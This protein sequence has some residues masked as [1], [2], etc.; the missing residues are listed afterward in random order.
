M[1]LLRHSELISSAPKWQCSQPTQPWLGRGFLREDRMTVYYYDL[2]TGTA[3]T[4]LTSHTADSGATWP[5]DADHY[6]GTGIVTLD[7][8]GGVYQSNTGSSINLSSAAMPSTQ[9]FEVLFSYIRKTSIAANAGLI[10]LSSPWPT[11]ADCYELFYAEG[12]GWLLYHTSISGSTNTLLAGP[13]AGPA[14]GVTWYMKVDV[15]T[16][17]GNTTF[18]VYYSIA[19]T[20]PFTQLFSYTAATSTDL[21]AVGTWFYNPSTASTA[22]TGQHIGALTVQDIPALSSATLSGP[23]QQL[24]SNPAEFT[25][26]LNEP[27]GTSGVVVTPSSSNGSDTFQAT[28]G[29]ANVTSI[30]LAA[31]QPSGTFWLTPG[32]TTGN[33]TVTITSSG[34]TTPGSPFTYDAMPLATS[35]TI[36]GAT[37][38]HQL[39]Q[40]TWTIALV[41]GDFAGTITA[42]P[43]GGAGQCQIFTPC[44]TTF[45]GTNTLSTTFSF[46]P[47]D[48]D[49]VTYTFTNS[50]SMT[51]PA[52]K[53]YTSTGEYL[54]DTFTGTQGTAIQSHT[55]GTLPDGIAGSTYTSPSAGAISLDG[56]GGAYLSTAGTA[57]SLSYATMPSSIPCE[58]VFEYRHLSTI[59]GADSGV[60]IMSDGDGNNLGYRFLSTIN[61][62]GWFQNDAY[63]TGAGSNGGPVI[64]ASWLIKL[65][66]QLQ[67][68]NNGWT[69]LYTQ[70]STD[71]GTTWALMSTGAPNPC[72]I[73]TSS[74]PAAI[75]AGLYFSGNAATSTTG[76]HIANLILQDPAPAPPTCSISTAYVTTSGQSVAF[77]FQTISG[78]TPATPT[79][80]N[81]APSFFRNGTSIGL[82]T[83]AWVTGYHSCAIVQLQPDV[84]INPGDTVTV[85]TPASWMS[86][87]TTNAANSVVCL[88]I[89]N[90]TG[91]SCFG[92][93][94][95]CKTFKP[96]FN[97]SDLG[98]TDGT[99]YNVPKNWRFRLTPSEAGSQN[100]VDGYPTVMLHPTE[101]LSFCSMNSA[102]GIDSTSYPGVPGYW[103]IG[104]DDNYQAYSGA[105]ATTI[106]IVAMSSDSV[107]TQDTTCTSVANTFT[108]GNVITTFAMFKVSQ[109]SGAATA[110]IPIGLQLYN[111]NSTPYISNLWIVAPGDFTYNQGTPLTFDRS[112][113]FAL[114]GQFLAHLANG[115]GSMRWMDATLGFASWTNMSEPWEQH[116]MTGQDGT[117]PAFSWNNSFYSQNQ[118]N[119][120]AARSINLSVS[121][122]V[123]TE[124]TGSPYNVTLNTSINATTT[125]L[126]I[127]AGGDAYAI[128][129][130]GLLLL[131][132][133]EKMRIRSVTG[134]SNPYTVTVERGSSGT[135]AVTHSAGTISCL[136]RVSITSLSQLG[137]QLVE[138]V[139]QSNHNLKTGLFS[140]FGYGSYPTMYFTDGSSNSLAGNSYCVMVTGPTSFVVDQR[141]G[142]GTLGPSTAYPDA[143]TSYTLDPASEYDISQLPPS[144]FP[145]EF[146]AMTTGS[147]TGCNLHV[148]IPGNASDSYVYDVATKICDNFPSGRIVYVEL[149]DEFWNG[150]QSEMYFTQ[151]ISRLCGYSDSNE[152]YVVRTGQI[153]TIFRAVFGSRANE[154]K[155]LL[156]IAWVSSSYGAELLNLAI[157]NGITIDTYAVAPYIDPDN[158]TPSITAWNNSATIQQM[159][160][161]WVHELYYN[162]NGVTANMSSH[163]TTI[164]NYNA[165]TGGTCFIY[166]YEGGFQT[167]V[168]SSANNLTTLSHDLPYDPNWR[169]IEKDFFALLQTSWFHNLNIYSYGIYYFGVNNWGVYHCPSQPYGKGDGSDGK[170]NNRLCL[171]TPGFTYTKAAT[172]NQDQQNVSVRGQAFLEWMQPAQ[173][174]KGML[175][176]PYRFVNR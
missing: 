32:G 156:N 33:R 92:T 2:F 137:N 81:F 65:T 25:V 19:S 106:S 23:T 170:A 159:V 60:L 118:I 99:R 101:Q 77:F 73:L 5:N 24:F 71:G 146:I 145:P 138:M 72:V 11:I 169:I 29:G 129:I 18:T 104:F 155:A 48:A 141:S 102:N 67:V 34:L 139:T 173:A 105:A 28:Q 122:Y 174:K 107:V 175:F 89:G 57:I 47:L 84:Q 82:G 54:A 16:S 31:G 46:T 128:P 7:G 64:G 62:L 43:G 55:S 90:N 135:T 45:T 117:T 41:G 96:G 126:S 143:P 168:P 127:N 8:L 124:W 87:G 58:L 49:S 12:D 116:Q 149:A 70:Y 63:I 39:V 166:G 112:N 151:V 38:G 119:Y 27:A 50:G 140:S 172:T 36:T 163:A 37:G 148:N 131:A 76:S 97:F 98:T 150:G 142:T 164:A 78:S 56:S 40:A 154:V 85:S 136:N 69:E 14:F 15:S 171:A 61:G 6:Y 51:N 114:S 152:W 115:A 42:T 132:G 133:T 100:T 75:T 4:L 10:F 160:D 91:V 21:V 44:I 130:T 109:A 80:M 22:T 83:N 162:T 144:G 153:R 74:L 59:S 123:Y 13:Y 93:N 17:G 147:F 20:G 110:T 86:L 52:T 111:A 79:A 9:N 113:P 66:V 176:V 53:T 95:L 120:T 88:A 26:G 165:S 30:T 68:S 157:A 121:P 103:A 134:T 3:G 167:G 161:L 125:T 1:T 108:T 158:S 94:T 35:Y